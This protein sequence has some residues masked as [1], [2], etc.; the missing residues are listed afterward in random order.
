MSNKP[1]LLTGSG[2]S[3]QVPQLLLRACGDGLSA[4][5]DSSIINIIVTEPRR[6]AAI[7]VSDRCVPQP[8][9]FQFY[10]VMAV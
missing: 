6:V 8:E 3:T 4:A 9:H 2:K 5:P 1:F 10:F 7:S